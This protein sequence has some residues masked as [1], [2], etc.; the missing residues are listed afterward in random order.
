M[1]MNKRLI[2]IFA[3]IA[4]FVLTLVVGAV[5]FTV[6]DVDILLQSEKNVQFNKAAI[7]ETSGIKKGQ[8]VFTID[9]AKASAKIEK[10]F[11]ELIVV[12]IERE[13]PNKVRI[14]LGARTAILKIKIANSDKYAVL[15][16]TIVENEN[17]TDQYKIID[18]VDTESEVYND[19]KVILISGYEFSGNEDCVGDFINFAHDQ[20]DSLK[21]LK[22]I[23]NSLNSYGVV[24]E[25][26]PATFEKIDIID[27]TIRLKTVLGITMV[28]R[29]DTN[30]GV[31]T[32]CEAIYNTFYG[33]SGEDRELANYLYMNNN[34]D[35]SNSSKLDFNI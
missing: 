6:N 10:Q 21:D 18:V 2:V 5:V 33:M 14:R 25:R 24:N 13:F 15:D 30:I 27:N 12:G 19:S 20:V 3:C 4:V 11:P 31:K 35:I 16:Y 34:G 22:D 1:F 17:K 8:S 28:I 29:T 32:Q 9:S 23:L 26:V 7:L